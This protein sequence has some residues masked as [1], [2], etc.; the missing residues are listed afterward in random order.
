MG[1]QGIHRP[2]GEERWKWRGCHG[3]GAEPLAWS[4]APD[5]FM[6]PGGLGP[7]RLHLGRRRTALGVVVFPGSRDRLEGC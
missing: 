5:G 6:P 7:R 2:L 4:L 1:A 3:R